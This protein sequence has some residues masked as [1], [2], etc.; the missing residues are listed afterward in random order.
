MKAF[1]SVVE[2]NL[3]HRKKKVEKEGGFG[4]HFCFVDWCEFPAFKL[5]DGQAV[6]LFEWVECSDSQS[7]QI[8]SKEKKCELCFQFVEA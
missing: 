3:F 1:E 2:V 5:L 4:I 6:V 8:A 7:I